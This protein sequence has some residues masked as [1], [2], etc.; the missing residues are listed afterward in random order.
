MRLYLEDTA[1]L[2]ST[3]YLELVLRP[4]V[5]LRGLRE[6]PRDREYQPKPLDRE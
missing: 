5:Q 3:V 1:G 2:G 6:Y 4:G